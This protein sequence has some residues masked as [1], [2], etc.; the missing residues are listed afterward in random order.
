VVRS[1]AELSVPVNGAAGGKALDWEQLEK[2]R[3]KIVMQCLKKE[4]GLLDILS[5][6]T[7]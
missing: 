3:H 7:A 2:R 4:V 6:S 1:A 5:F